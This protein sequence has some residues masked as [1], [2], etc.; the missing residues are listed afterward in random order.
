MCT[1][2]QP[3]SAEENGC[4]RKRV[5]FSHCHFP[6]SALCVLTSLP[7]PLLLLSLHH[8]FFLFIS[9]RYPFFLVYCLPSFFFTLKA[10][11]P[12]PQFRGACRLHHG[13]TSVVETIAYSRC[14]KP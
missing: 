13:R 9:A 2:G 3:L 5:S 6:T 10:S 1:S 14:R 7:L 11:S 4:L 12:L 8:L